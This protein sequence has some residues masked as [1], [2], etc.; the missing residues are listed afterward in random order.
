MLKN[1]YPRRFFLLFLQKILKRALWTETNLIYII[2]VFVV[3][4]VCIHI[5][6]RL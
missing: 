6:K 3:I 5:I 4:V 2:V 1:E